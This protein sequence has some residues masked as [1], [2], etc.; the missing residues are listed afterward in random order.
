MLGGFRSPG[1][2]RGREGGRKGGIDDSEGA[3]QRTWSKEQK[4]TKREIES[5]DCVRAKC[6]IK[7]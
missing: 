7:A 3:K 2:Q 6:E 5:G 1:T 4:S